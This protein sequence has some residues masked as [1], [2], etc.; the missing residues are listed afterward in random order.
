M[1]TVYL[2]Y[3]YV[4]KEYQCNNDH[5]TAGPFKKLDRAFVFRLEHN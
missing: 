3:S 4:G 1:C 5:F 2:M